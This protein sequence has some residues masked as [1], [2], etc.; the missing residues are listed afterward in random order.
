MRSKRLTTR[1][2]NLA[3]VI[4]TVLASCIFYAVVPAKKVAAACNCYYNGTAY[5]P[6]ACRGKQRCLGGDSACWWADDNN[7][8]S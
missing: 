6:G 5:S 1:A 4:M 8:G 7:C 2:M 3:A